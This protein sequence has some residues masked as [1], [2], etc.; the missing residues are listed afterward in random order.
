VSVTWE[1][2]FEKISKTLSTVPGNQMT[3]V[4]GKL[5]DAERF[6]KV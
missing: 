4:A 3:A 6:A 1:E 2:A 5:A